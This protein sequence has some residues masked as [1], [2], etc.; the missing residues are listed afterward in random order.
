M[1]RPLALLLSIGIAQ[2]M[3]GAAMAA[4]EEPKYDVILRQDA[5]ELRRYAPTIV[6]EVTLAGERDA[7][8]NQG[9]R[10]LAAYIFGGNAPKERIAMTAPVTQ[11]PSGAG[12]TI[13]MTTPVSAQ[14]VAGEWRIRFTMPSQYALS[15]LPT[16]DD[17]QVKLREVPGRQFA[18]IRFSGF[19]TDGALQE[20]TSELQAFI[21]SKGLV[22][23]GEPTYAFYDP[24]WTLPFMRRN[25]VL[26]E[27]D[28]FEPSP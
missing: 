22:P 23:I 4:T 17:P 3:T 7:A 20:R 15:T 9:F 10:L 19:R 16:P 5:F 26:W 6:A 14:A 11:S 24:P 18:V 12:E 13:A 8:L 1:H 27:V 2:L 21:R 28:A 25:E